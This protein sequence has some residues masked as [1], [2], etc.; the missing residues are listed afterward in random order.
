MPTPVT[1]NVATAKGVANGTLGILEYVHLPTIDLFTTAPLP[2]LSNCQASLQTTHSFACKGHTLLRF[3]LGLSPNYSPCFSQRKHIRKQISSSHRLQM[4]SRA[5]SK[6]ARSSSPLYAR[7]ARS[8]IKSK[9]K[10]CNP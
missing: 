1:Q 8:Y 6:C 10:H 7:L 3:A 4:G 5:T 9:E 2:Q